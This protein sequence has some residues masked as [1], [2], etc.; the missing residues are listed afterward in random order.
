MPLPIRTL[1]APSAPI[2]VSAGLSIVQI[3]RN[4]DIS[5]HADQNTD[6]ARNVDAPLN[7]AGNAFLYRNIYADEDYIISDRGNA[8]DNTV[9]D[10]GTPY[11]DAENQ[12][13]G[14]GF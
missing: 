10:L 14:P 8:E 7:V 9:A 2:A 6:S 12:A 5:P 3:T 4:R 11:P 13:A 1:N